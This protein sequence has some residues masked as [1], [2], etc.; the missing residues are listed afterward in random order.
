M[1]AGNWH[2]RDDPLIFDLRARLAALSLGTF[3][4][5]QHSVNHFHTDLG[6]PKDT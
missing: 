5:L 4:P 6:I 3:L 2:M 1:R